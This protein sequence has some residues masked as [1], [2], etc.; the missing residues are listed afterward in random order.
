MSL[1]SSLYTGVSG[2]QVSQRGLNTT[3]HNL[4]NL[5]TEGYVRQQTLQ[6]DSFYTN[7]GVNH[8]SYLQVGHGAA[9]AAI[10]QVRDTFLDKSYRQ[11]LGRQQF[12]QAQYECATEMEEILGE[13]EGV[14]FQDSTEELWVAM[15]ELCKEPD[16][17]VTRSSFIQTAVSFIERAETVYTQIKEYQLNL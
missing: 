17:I 8:I 12:Y 15:Q 14:A 7:V 16:S 11:E 13:T 4:S 5:E 1:M 6:T 3:A 9:A 10:T 2:L